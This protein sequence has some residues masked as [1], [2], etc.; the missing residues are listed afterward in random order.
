[1]SRH[2]FAKHRKALKDRNTRRLLRR[3]Q[4]DW[5]KLSD[6]SRGRRL[7]GLLDHGC[8]RRGLAQHQDDGGLSLPCS[9]GTLRRCLELTRLPQP[10]LG[11]VETDDLSPDAALLLTRC[12]RRKRCYAGRIANEAA[13]EQEVQH[14][15]ALLVSILDSEHVDYSKMRKEMIVE[16]EQRI[17]YFELLN[18]RNPVQFPLAS[19][20]PVGASPY[21][22]LKDS[23][24]V[25]KPSEEADSFGPE[26][27]IEQLMVFLLKIAPLPA[28]RDEALRRLRIQYQM[29]L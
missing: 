11:R 27:L 13:K 6:L 1:M 10:L 24:P 4:H 22:V 26:V 7:Q 9:E 14:L 12:W 21:T 25:M 23:R 5:P 16:L 19:P 20:A 3:V 18:R 15:M 8:T 29:A 28:A 2:N 17:Y